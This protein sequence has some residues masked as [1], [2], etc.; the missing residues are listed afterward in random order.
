MILDQQSAP[1]EVN[2]GIVSQGQ[3]ELFQGPLTVV[4]EMQDI[5]RLAVAGIAPSAANF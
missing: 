5:A 1:A 4:D 2:P 3:Q